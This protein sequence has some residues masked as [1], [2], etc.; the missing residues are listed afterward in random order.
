MDFFRACLKKIR[1]CPFSKATGQ[2]HVHEKCFLGALC[3]SHNSEIF[4]FAT[5]NRDITVLHQQMETL[6]MAS[7]TYALNE[8]NDYKQPK[9]TVQRMVKTN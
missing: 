9:R 4:Q 6:N 8:T 2:G 5:T 3:Y 1:A 7:S